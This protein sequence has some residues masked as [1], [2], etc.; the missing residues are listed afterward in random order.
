MWSPI[1]R[2]FTFMEGDPFPP[3]G[4]ASS[5]D[6]CVFIFQLMFKICKGKGI[7]SL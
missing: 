3:S 6:N 7:Q 5:Y 2:F 1:A 4:L